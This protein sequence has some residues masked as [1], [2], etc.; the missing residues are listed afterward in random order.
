MKG[1]IAVAVGTLAFASSAAG[2]DPADVYDWRPPLTVD[3][4]LDRNGQV[5]S[6]QLGVA[7]RSV[8]LRVTLNSTPLPLIEIPID[9]SKEFGIC[10]GSAPSIRLA[11]QSEAPLN[12]LGQTPRGYEI[13]EGCME[14]V[15]GGGECDSIH[16][17]WDT[18]T[19]QLA[20]WRA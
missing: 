19:R 17:Y 12:A 10:P 4:D 7:A 6:A 8:G 18:T 13:C 5:D 3:V 11:P 20:W 16:F 9:G 15:V 1:I 2:S 14:V